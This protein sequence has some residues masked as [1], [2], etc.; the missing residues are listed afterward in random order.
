M[1]PCCRRGLPLLS[2]RSHLR[3]SLRIIRVLFWCAMAVT[4]VCLLSPADAVL[5]AKV[6]VAS[7]LPYSAQLDAADFTSHSDKLIHASLFALLGW[8]GARSWMQQRQRWGLV[9]GLLVLGVLTEALQS[10]IPGRS[11]SLGDWLADAFG[12]AAGLLSAPPAV[13][14]NI[15]SAH[16]RKQLALGPKSPVFREP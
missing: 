16:R 7:W 13:V 12:V 10:Q 9:A 5:A 8:L 14:G 4:L 3:K 15:M 6:W 1:A 11:A 2:R